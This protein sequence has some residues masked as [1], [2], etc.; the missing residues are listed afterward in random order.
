MRHMEILTVH[1]PLT[2]LTL[3]MR[4]DDNDGGSSEGGDGGGDNGSNIT[5]QGCVDVNDQTDFFYSAF[6]WTSE[7]D[8]MCHDGYK[9][10]V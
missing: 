10:T 4:D 3:W 8:L 5:N 2:I 1:C 9:L 6:Y 7:N